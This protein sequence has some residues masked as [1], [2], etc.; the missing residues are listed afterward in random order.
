MSSP[1]S[2]GRALACHRTM[3]ST[4]S[5]NAAP[6]ST[7]TAVG[8]SRRSHGTDR[9]PGPAHQIPGA[10]RFDDG[11]LPRTGVHALRGRTS[12]GVV[13][14]VSSLPSLLLSGPGHVCPERGTTADHPKVR[15]IRSR[16]VRA[17]SRVYPAVGPTGPC[18]VTTVQNTP[19]S[20]AAPPGR[21]H[22]PPGGRRPAQRMAQAK[23][24]PPFGSSFCPILLRDA[25][26]RSGP[27]GPHGGHPA[28]EPVPGRTAM[29]KR[30]WTD[31]IC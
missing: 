20:D 7:A 25:L 23:G 14:V 17:A 29:L 12:S 4:A 2:E 1:S 6:R 22:Q 27:H 30:G 31:R 18:G 11:C 10:G 15:S 8:S 26:V 5:L 16:S 9:Q 19:N 28:P 24:R 13:A 21:C 3:V